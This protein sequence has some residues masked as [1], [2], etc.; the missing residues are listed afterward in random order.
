MGN[1][2]GVPDDSIEQQYYQAIDDW[3]A[4]LAEILQM[5]HRGDLR[6]GSW[7]PEDWTRHA[8]ELVGRYRRRED[9]HMLV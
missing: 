3:T 9:W 2:V 8:A 4:M 1:Q 7:H 5:L 6:Y